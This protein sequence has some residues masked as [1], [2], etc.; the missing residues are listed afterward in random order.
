VASAAART[1][2]EECAGFAGKLRAKTEGMHPGQNPAV[3][4]GTAMEI[5]GCLRG[6]KIYL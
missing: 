5:L 6:K 3:K 1:P 2:D 4:T